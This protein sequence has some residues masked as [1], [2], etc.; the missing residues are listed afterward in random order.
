MGRVL[1]SHLLGIMLDTPSLAKSD[2]KVKA[3]WP[4]Y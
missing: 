2:A 1:V 4:F 3:I